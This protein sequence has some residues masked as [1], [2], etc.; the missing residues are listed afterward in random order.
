M[1]AH[2][3]LL[4]A[5]TGSNKTNLVY[6]CNLNFKLTKKWLP[7]LIAKGLLSFYE[8]PPKTW[9]TTEKGKRFIEAMESVFWIWDDDKITQDEIVLEAI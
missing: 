1:I 9:K 6:K 2:D 7:Q 3:I 5:T 8:G 4:E